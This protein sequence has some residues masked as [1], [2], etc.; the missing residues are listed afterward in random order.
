MSIYSTELPETINESS[1]K[2]ALGALAKC[3]VCKSNETSRRGGYWSEK[4]L[5]SAI[6]EAEEKRGQ[7]GDDPFVT[8]GEALAYLEDGFDLVVEE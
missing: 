4:R 1:L 6:E 3:N 2:T 8:V 5:D 7:R